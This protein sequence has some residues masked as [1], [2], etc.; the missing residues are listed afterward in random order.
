[1]WKRL[2]EHVRA[3]AA[4]RGSLVVVTGPIF[5]TNTPVRM[6]GESHV[7]I[8][9][10]FYKAV[11]AE[12]SPQG[13]VA[14][15]LPHEGTQAAFC[16]FVTNVDAVEEMTGLNFFSALPD[17]IETNLERCIDASLSGASAP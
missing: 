9:D 15:V 8:P 3:L 4:R 7:R 11:Y 5:Y 6:I 2:E 13:M 14:F 17:G 10:A 16:A 12:T 1:V